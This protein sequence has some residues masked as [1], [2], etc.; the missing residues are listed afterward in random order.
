MM[1]GR[2]IGEYISIKVNYAENGS[3]VSVLAAAAVMLLVDA[4]HFR[5]GH[6]CRRAFLVGPICSR[7]ILQDAPHA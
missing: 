3:R 4:V 1:R 5:E 2:W 6:R 7:E